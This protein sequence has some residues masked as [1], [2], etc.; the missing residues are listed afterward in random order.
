MTPQMLVIRG[1]YKLLDHWPLILFA[2]LV[3]VPALI[4]HHRQ[5]NQ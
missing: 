3:S 4:K 1:I 2:I 5:F